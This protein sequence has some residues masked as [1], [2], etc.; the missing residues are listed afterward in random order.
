M[1]SS[2]LGNLVRIAPLRLSDLP[3]HPSI[4]RDP[5]PDSTSPS[6]GP[7]LLTFLRAIL[8]EASI[9]LS[10]ATFTTNFTYLSTK[11]SPPSTSPVELY[12][13]EVPASEQSSINWS[14]NQKILRR[15]PLKL[16]DENWFARRSVHKNESSKTR[17]GSASWPEFIFG[18]KDHHSKHE[19]DFTSTLYDAH[20]ILDWNDEIRKLQEDR[21]S[22][23]PWIDG[24]NGEKYT[25][26]T[27]ES[28]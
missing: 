13:R 20:Y 4:P 24:E 14:E 21:E 17:E 28:S 8:D 27:M 9:F 19:Q 26:I 18:L 25:D 5:Q 15:K 6:T 1:P 10:P 7:H 2:A 11:P 16:E 22:G 23:E 12:K 3:S